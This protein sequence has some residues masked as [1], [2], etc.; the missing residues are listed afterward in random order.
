MALYS[1]FKRNM[2]HASQEVPY[3][4]D[5][6]FLLKRIYYSHSIAINYTMENFRIRFIKARATNKKKLTSKFIPRILQAIH[7]VWWT[8]WHLATQRKRPIYFVG[9]INKFGN[10]CSTFT[11][12]LS[13]FSPLSLS[14]SLTSIN[15]SLLLPLLHPLH[16]PF[17]PSPSVSFTLTLI[18]CKLSPAKNELK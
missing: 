9:W 7:F 11:R 8:L 4:F 10:Y 16:R 12:L 6:W 17:P 14:L 5:K 1:S 3:N 13:S 18:L 15:L 2:I